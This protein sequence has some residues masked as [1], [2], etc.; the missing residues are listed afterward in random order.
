MLQCN[1]FT[2]SRILKTTHKNILEFS[3]LR[4]NPTSVTEQKDGNRKRFQK[5][6][7]QK[8][9]FFTKQFKPK[10][11]IYSQV[12]LGQNC[13]Q[14]LDAALNGSFFSKSSFI[15]SGVN[16]LRTQG[17]LK[18]EVLFYSIFL[19]KSVLLYLCQMLPPI[20]EITTGIIMII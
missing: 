3:F 7:K 2:K 17:Q 6:L 11:V 4:T 19:G 13:I 16:M 1:G 15:K 20:S 5:D 10:V 12:I 8:R 14:L 18:S 9:H